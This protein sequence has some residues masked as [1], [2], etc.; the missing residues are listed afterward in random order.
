M[1]VKSCPNLVELRLAEIGQLD[2]A[3][4]ESISKLKKLVLL[5]LSSPGTTLSQEVVDKLL[6]KVGAGLVHLDLSDNPALEDELLLSIAK[7]CPKLRHL[8]LRGLHNLSDEAVAA[9]FDKLEQ[10]RRPGLESIDLEKG[11][12]LEGKALRSLIK[13]SGRSIENLSILGWRKVDPDAVSDLKKCSSLKNLNVGWC[14]TVTDYSL[15]DI[16][17]SCEQIE[18]IKVWGECKLCGCD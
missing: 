16:L 13:H 4:L 17:D 10:D 15:K 18:S 1:L 9:F 14:R 6:Q 8:S 12:D 7:Y 3:C 2:D 11:D 5:D